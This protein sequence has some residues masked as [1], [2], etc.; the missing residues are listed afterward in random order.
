MGAVRDRTRRLVGRMGVFA[1]GVVCLR[2]RRG[3]Y[4]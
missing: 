2:F 3:H 4:A 1:D